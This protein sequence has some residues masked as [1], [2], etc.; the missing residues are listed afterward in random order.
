MIYSVVPALALILNLILNRE[1]LKKFRFTASKADKVQTVY[2]RY[3]HFLMAVSVYFVVDLIWGILYEHRDIPAL[4]P[5]T[6][7]CT[8]LYFVFMLVNMVTWTRFVVA[9]LAEGGRRDYAFL[10]SVWAMFILGAFFLMLNR[11]RPFIFTHNEAHE[12][13]ELPGRYLLLSVQILFYVLTSIY[14][15]VVARKTTGQ[16]H[17]RYTAVAATGVVMGLA[18]VG[19][20]VY[21]F[22]PTYATGLIIGI[23]LVHCFVEEA[24]KKEKEVHDH[25]ASVMAEDYEA[26]FYI[27]IDTGVFLEFSKSKKYS[28]MKVPVKGM[29]FY[30]E[31]LESIETYVYPPDREYARSFYSRETML[32][33]LEG[34]RSFSFKYR[35]LVEGEPRYFLFTVMRDSNGQYLIFYEK[36]INDELA[37]EKNQKENQKKTIT[38]GQIAESLASSY[39]EIYYVNVQDSSFV[40]YEVNNIFGQL[41]ISKSGED[42][43]KESLENIPQIVHKHDCDSVAEF[44]NRDNMISSLEIH[45]EHSIDYRI[46]VDGKTRF[47]RMIVKKPSDG[48][49]FIIGVEDIDAEVQREKQQLK[50][51]KT[52]KEL[53]R[54]DELTGIKNKTA[55]KELEESVQGNMDNGMDYLDFGLVVC[56]A[57][58]LKQIND[59]LGHATGDEYIKASARMLCDIFVHSP[60]F[61]VGG[62][63]FVVFLRGS[64]FSDRIELMDKLRGNVLENKKAGKGVILASG[65]SE[66]NPENDSLVSDIFE[67]ADKRMYE[68]KQRLKSF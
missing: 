10:H 40:S 26:I 54:R 57:N 34:R 6:Y 37:A 16:R 17:V 42:F 39:D 3:A 2:I 5:F 50:A 15:F 41:E 32:K 45:K 68:D 21:A 43:F 46:M 66:Y 60:V 58:N 59:T 22:L 24:E 35:V 12:Y 67:R 56:D 27:E 8:V 19:Q 63:E 55:Y 33:N 51:L 25:I 14:M 20:I 49:H 30:A 29:D 18:L 64:D 52:E 23:C 62:D 61:R 11:F 38:F 9:Y 28:E 36:D 1:S 65:M 53:A 31:T 44:I 4:F 47:T 48:T 13:I 7:S